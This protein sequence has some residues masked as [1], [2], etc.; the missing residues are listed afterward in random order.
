[1]RA[2]SL[3]R[4]TVRKC[5]REAKVEELKYRRE[6]VPMKLTPLM[7]ATELAL[8]TDAH[9]PKKE[10][11]TAKALH[12]EIARAGIARMRALVEPSTRAKVF[13]TGLASCVS[14]ELDG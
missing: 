9:R 1:M 6:P 2:T 7:A 11:R 14:A 13:P 3:S 4:N 12:K 8:I 10:H 5:L